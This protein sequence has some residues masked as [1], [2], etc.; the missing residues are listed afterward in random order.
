M[1]KRYLIVLIICLAAAT[2]YFYLGARR[3]YRDF[4]VIHN[5]NTVSIIAI[6]NRGASLMDVDGDSIRRNKLLLA[7]D[8]SQ[9]WAAYHKDRYVAALSSGN[10]LSLV[11]TGGTII[12]TLRLNNDRKIVDLCFYPSASQAEMLF[13]ITGDSGE[14]Y[15]DHIAG[16]SMTDRLN[17]V[18]SKDMADYSPW[19]IQTADVDGDGAREISIG[20][21][22]TARLHPVMAKRP[23]IYCWDGEGLRPRWLG[24]RLSR[25]F[26]EYV[27]GDLDGDG[28]DEIIAVEVL[29]D[30]QNIVQCYGWTGFGFQGLAE[31]VPAQAYEGIRAVDAGTAEGRGVLV[32]YRD[33]GSCGIRIFSYKDGKLEAV[34]SIEGI[35]ALRFDGAGGRLFYLEKGSISVS[36]L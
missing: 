34:H 5:G 12:D 32:R 2:A 14:W 17:P 31:G 10:A 36:N 7:G 6:D 20:V 11:D 26:T 35:D 18:Y 21:Y 29:K 28:K 13:I 23:F 4:A 22:K 16:Y 33:G 30:G 1:Q 27:F 3:N 15:G 8:F 24:S 19:R 9:C 25:P